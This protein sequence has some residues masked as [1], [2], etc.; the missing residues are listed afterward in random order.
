MMS[1]VIVEMKIVVDPINLRQPHDRSPVSTPLIFERAPQP[2]DKDAVQGTTYAIHTNSVPFL[3]Q[4]PREVDAG[5]V[6][7]L[8]GVEDLRRRLLSTMSNLLADG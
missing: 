3:L 8:V 1:V 5:E 7:A 6:S 4:T 2:F